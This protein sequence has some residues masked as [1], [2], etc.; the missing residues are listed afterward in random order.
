MNTCCFFF[1]INSAAI[2]LN[3][4]CSLMMRKSSGNET[5]IAW[6]YNNM[7]GVNACMLLVI[8]YIVNIGKKEIYNVYLVS[9]SF[10]FYKFSV[11]TPSMHRLKITF[12]YFWLKKK[13]RNLWIEYVTEKNSIWST[14]DEL[15]Y[16]EHS[17]HTTVNY[18]NQKECKKSLI[19]V[20]E[21]ALHIDYSTLYVCKTCDYY[22]LVKRKNV[23][24]NWNSC[25]PNTHTKTKSS[26][27]MSFKKSC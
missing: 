1:Q 21:F 12:R 13:I 7:K 17:V 22:I 8:C 26:K 14:K 16:S 4:I 5:T 19:H 2:Y 18:L 20:H 27:S 23:S 10:C 3:F 15:K 6:M 24:I 9:F 25:S 11:H